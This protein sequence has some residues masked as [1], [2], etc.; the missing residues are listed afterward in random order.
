[1]NSTISPSV[2]TASLPPLKHAWKG[3]ICQGTASEILR[4][5]VQEHLRFLQKE[6]GYR[7]IRFHATFHEDLGVVERA[8]DGSLVFNWALVDKVYDFLVEVGFDP[9]VELNHALEY[10]GAP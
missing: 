5:D 9:I 10:P 7:A 2:A 1:M 8:A 3:C 6:L 4:A